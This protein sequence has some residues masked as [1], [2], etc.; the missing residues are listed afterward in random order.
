VKAGGDRI[1]V[2][3]ISVAQ[4]EDV[5]LA[6][7]PLELRD[8]AVVVAAVQAAAIVPPITMVATFVVAGPVLG[9]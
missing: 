3:D 7:A 9:A 8:I 4:T 1:T 2:G 6:G 5:W